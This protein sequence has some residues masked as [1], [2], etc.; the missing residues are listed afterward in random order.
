[1]IRNVLRLY[2]HRH[3][4]A[5]RHLQ[6]VSQK[7]KACHV[8]A[9]VHAV[10]HKHIM[11]I[12]IER[13]HLYIK[14]VEQRLLHQLSLCR[15]REN[16]HA[17][18]LRQ[19]Q[20]V[21]RTRAAVRPHLIRL[22]KAGHREAINRLRSMNRMAAGDNRA[23][24]IGL[25]IAAAQNLLHRS[26]IHLLG[27]AHDVQRQTRLTAHRIHIA[28]GIRRC[29]LAI[30]KRVIHNRRKKIR[31]LHNRQ[32]LTHLINAGI[33]AL[34][35]AD[36]KPLVIMR[37]KAL[38]QIAQRACAHLGATACTACQLRQLYLI[39]HSF[40]LRLFSSS[41]HNLIAIAALKH[42]LL[43]LRCLQGLCILQRH[44][45]KKH[46]G[47]AAAAQ[48]ARHRPQLRLPASLHAKVL[49]AH[50]T[51]MRKKR[52]N[53]LPHLLKERVNSPFSSVTTTL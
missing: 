24:L 15:R 39:F 50:R 9:G 30:H 19:N 22:H 44:S 31:R 40:N 18:G 32:L 26:L 21:A 12:L 42:Q 10:V 28:Q 16:A 46:T 5:L 23:C 36:Q 48:A 37:L 7:G 3:A 43:Q 45:L 6:A 17:Q 13:A 33:V 27:N 11:R 4:A 47:A 29:N 8:S 2:M 14:L 1:M 41:I 52:S 51:K 34:V 20:N 25:G 53:I 38:Q 35:I 49:E